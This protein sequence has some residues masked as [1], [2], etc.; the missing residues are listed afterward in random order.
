MALETKWPWS[1]DPDSTAMRVR[2]LHADEW[3]DGLMFAVPSR[4][5]WHVYDSLRCS[6]SKA[7][8]IRPVLYPYLPTG[9]SKQQRVL[10]ARRALRRVLSALRSHNLVRYSAREELWSMYRQVPPPN[11]LRFHE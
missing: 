7:A 5:V 10:A 4:A 9:L 3:E 8:D 2:A 11:G 6:P 1:A